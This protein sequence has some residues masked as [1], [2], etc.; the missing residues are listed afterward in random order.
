MS[1]AVE[2]MFS[3]REK[4]W[5]GLGE[6]VESAPTMQDALRLS[7]LD[8]E[9][10]KRKVFTT[11]KDKRIAVPNTFA[12]VRDTDG[13]VLGTV[14]NKYTVVQNDEAFQFVD[15]MKIDGDVEFETAGSLNGGSTV[16]ITA[17]MGQ[18]N[19]LGDAV[20]KY[21]VFSNSHN[22]SSRVRMVVTPIRVVCNNT[23]NMALRTHDR[24]WSA[25]HTGSINNKVADAVAGLGFANEYY[26]E[27]QKAAE[28]LYKIKFSRAQ[29]EALLDQLYPMTDEYS[30][31]KKN[32]YEYNRETLTR[33][34]MM[35]DL[36]DVRGTAW[37]VVNA[38]SDYATHVP[39]RGKDLNQ[40]G[41]MYTVINGIGL[42][43]QVYEM[44]LSQ[45]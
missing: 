18:F 44:M 38:V 14:G 30:A 34:Y 16:F 12:T 2:T 28:D 27:L 6:V 41:V 33:A 22:G 3:V 24:S 1:A 29:F 36:N 45:V 20:D 25:V 15:Q 26:A 17:K 7:G 10:K 32:T 11:F 35:D 4:P 31:R 23:L 21:L 8:W 5:H 13:A 37:G 39:N 43:Q 9:V 42:L 19:L 40:E